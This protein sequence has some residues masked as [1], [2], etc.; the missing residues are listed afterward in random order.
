MPGSTVA[1]P[2]CGV[3]ELEVGD[4]APELALPGRPRVKLCE[5]HHRDS[6]RVLTAGLETLVG[7]GVPPQ[8]LVAGYDTIKAGVQ[9]FQGVRELARILSV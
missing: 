9:A 3:C 6:Q 7:L 8:A 2:K 5:A 4:D 1:P